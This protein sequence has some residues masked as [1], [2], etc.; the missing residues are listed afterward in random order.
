[1]A[2]Y[3]GYDEKTTY[4]RNMEKEITIGVFG[5]TMK[6]N[7][8]NFRQSSIQ[9]VMKRIRTKGAKVIVYESTLKEGDTSL[10]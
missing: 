5:L 10:S 1:M 2:G 3:Y 8:D 4:D 9:C 7:S 6:S